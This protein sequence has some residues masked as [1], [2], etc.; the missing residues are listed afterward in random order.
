MTIVKHHEITS[1]FGAL[2]VELE[3]IGEGYSGDYDPNDPR[4]EPL[5]RFTVWLDG[6]LV[7]Q[8]SYCTLLPAT[9]NTEQLKKAAKI[10]FDAAHESLL[11]DSFGRKMQEISWIGPDWL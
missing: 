11:D 5:I 1:D 3:D 4:D 10:I 7:P 9:L 8:G 2:A 6:E